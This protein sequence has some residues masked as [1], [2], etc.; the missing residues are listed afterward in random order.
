MANWIVHLFWNWGQDPDNFAIPYLTA[1]GDLL[2]TAFL[3]VAFHML[4]LSGKNVGLLLDM[5]ILTASPNELFG[6][7]D[8]SYNLGY[9]NYLI[10]GFHY[11]V[12]LYC[13]FFKNTLV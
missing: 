1:I 8:P 13:K 3:A 6:L 11:E 2:G 10:K 4:Y 9:W 5:V 12:F 7:D